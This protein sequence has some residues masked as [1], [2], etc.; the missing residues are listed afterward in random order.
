[1]SSLH[2]GKGGFTFAT[3]TAIVN[4]ITELY[5]LQRYFQEDL[6]IQKHITSLN[7]WLAL[8]GKITTDWELPPEG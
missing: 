5:S 6:L 1:M 2:G 4:S 8:F 7:D 3:G